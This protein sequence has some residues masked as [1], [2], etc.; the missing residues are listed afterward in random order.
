MRDGST[1]KQNVAAKQQYGFDFFIDFFALL[2]THVRNGGG[3][4]HGTAKNF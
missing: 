2:F 3:L 1:I 4:A